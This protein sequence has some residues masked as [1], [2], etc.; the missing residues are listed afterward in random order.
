MLHLAG[1]LLNLSRDLQHPLLK[2]CRRMRLRH[3]RQHFVQDLFHQLFPL[4]LEPL[5]LP[6]LLEL[7]PEALLHLKLSI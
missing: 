4:L 6:Y 7:A 5:A 2:R 1:E 3:L